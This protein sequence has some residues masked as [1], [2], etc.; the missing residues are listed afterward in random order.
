M[1]E[2]FVR[3]KVILSQKG[4]IILTMLYKSCCTYTG[5]SPSTDTVNEE[6]QSMVR[7]VLITVLIITFAIV[8]LPVIIHVV[9]SL[10]T[11]LYAYKKEDN[12]RKVST[13]T[14]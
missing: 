13:K 12:K 5:S 1:H 7:V 11:L 2:I 10:C 14:Q 6:K 3:A 9:A 8:V 4:V